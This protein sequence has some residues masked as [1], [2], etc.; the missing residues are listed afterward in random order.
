MPHP[1]ADG[2]LAACPW[3]PIAD[4]AFLSDCEVTALVAPSE[5]DVF[6]HG[7]DACGVFMHL[8]RAD[9]EIA[10][11]QQPLDVRRGESK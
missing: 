11:A 6:E 5:A 2:P 10:L 8:I 3:P 9:H 4:D 1:V 7:V